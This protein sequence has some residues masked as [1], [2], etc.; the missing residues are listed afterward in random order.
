MYKKLEIK[1]EIPKKIEI[2]EVLEGI[3]KQID[4]GEYDYLTNKEGYLLNKWNNIKS[5]VV[6]GKFRIKEI[7]ED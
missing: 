4:K 6:V 7:K 5:N 2:K 3:I 1:A